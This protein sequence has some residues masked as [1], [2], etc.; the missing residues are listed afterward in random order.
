MDHLLDPAR[1]ADNIGRP[2]DVRVL[3]PQQLDAIRPIVK[4]WVDSFGVAHLQALHDKMTL[5]RATLIPVPKLQLKTRLE[6]RSIS[7]ETAPYKAGASF[8]RRHFADSECPSGPRAPV[9]RWRSCAKARCRSGP[10]KRSGIPARSTTVPRAMRTVRCDAADVKGGANA[11]A[12]GAGETRRSSARPAAARAKRNARRVT[13]TVKRHATA[14]ARECA[15]MARDARFAMVADLT[16]ATPARMDSSIA[17]HAPAEE[18]SA[19][20]PAVPPDVCHALAAGEKAGLHV[21]HV[22]EAANSLSA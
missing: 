18:S 22:R 4:A 5:T 13:A 8:N 7:K 19:V 10:R 15:L 6:K 16:A 11:P 12:V 21:R 9:I 17:P 1:N 2:S 14:A 3:D 20:R